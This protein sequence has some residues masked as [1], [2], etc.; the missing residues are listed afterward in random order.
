MFSKMVAL[1]TITHLLRL[2]YNA[3]LMLP[4]LYN[5]LL[6]TC[7]FLSFFIEDIAIAPMSSRKKKS[8]QVDGPIST[9]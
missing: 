7:N 1:T 6:F 5:S 9:G 2:Q 4:L 3:S 8:D